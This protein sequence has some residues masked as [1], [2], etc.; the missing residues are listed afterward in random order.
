MF[1][2][3]EFRNMNMAGDAEVYVVIMTTSK[4]EYAEPIKARIF[5]FAR[6]R[7]C[8][9]LPDS[10]TIDT[11]R[12]SWSLSEP[13]EKGATALWIVKILTAIKP[14]MRI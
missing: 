11:N 10:T 6:D 13:F 2:L 9:H 7:S 4:T 8:W 3:T 12:E 14:E 5:A 1:V